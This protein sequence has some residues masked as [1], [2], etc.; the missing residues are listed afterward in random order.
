MMT[1]GVDF[2]FGRTVDGLQA[3]NGQVIGVRVGDEMLSADRYV[4]A[5]G[6]YS[7]G[8]LE[9]TVL[10]ETY[11]IAVTRFDDRIRVGGMAKWGGFDLPLNPAR[12]KIL[13]IVVTDSFPGSSDVSQADFWTGLR[14]MAPDST[15]I[16]GRT[17]Y[18]NLFLNTGHGTLG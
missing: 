10:D 6:S 12:R 18:S 17:A 8:F 13:E 2:R 5:F 1:P 9:S 3:Q 7:R 11:K 14:P 16:V 15:P 4:V